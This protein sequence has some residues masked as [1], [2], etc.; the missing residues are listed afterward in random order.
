VNIE[1]LRNP[2]FMVSVLLLSGGAFL[3]AV[4]GASM[5]GW[6][7]IVLGAGM[8]LFARYRQGV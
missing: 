6:S 1:F 3:V 4:L 2:W 7:S 5:A 8:F